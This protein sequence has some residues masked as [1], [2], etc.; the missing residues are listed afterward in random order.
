[1]KRLLPLIGLFYSI[2]L[3][4]QT[5]SN[6]K[7]SYNGN[8]VTI[9]YDMQAKSDV[10]IYQIQLYSSIDQYK[11]PIKSV[12][13]DV[14]SNVKSGTK[15]TIEWDIKNDLES[16]DGDVD[17]KIQTT[18]IFAPWAV[19]KPN[20]Q[21]VR[22]GKKINVEWT[23]YRIGNSDVVLEL[24]KDGQ[25]L[26]QSF[27]YKNSGKVDF[28]ISKSIAKGKGYQIKVSSANSQ[29]DAALSVQFRIKRKTPLLLVLSPFILAGGG[30]AAFIA[31]QPKEVEKVPDNDLPIPPNNP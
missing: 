20:F 3:H 8:K 9:T 11:N 18:L 29:N 22:R 25:P 6:L 2:V 7:A 30:I 1:M 23:G 24:I 13:G 4:S 21:S 12:K 26:N 5:I 16:F 19:T 17:F 27:E 31:L 10:F 28:P 15:K 14:G